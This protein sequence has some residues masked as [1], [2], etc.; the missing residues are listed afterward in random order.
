MDGSA[1]TSSRY[2]ELARSLAGQ[3]L[4]AAEDAPPHR[5]RGDRW[6]RS[7]TAAMPA[8][9]AL[10]GEAPAELTH[11]YR[12]G[13][14][15]LVEAAER[16]EAGESACFTDGFG[17][18]R[19]IYTLLNWHLHL[20]AAIDRPGLL[21]DETGDTRALLASTRSLGAFLT[22]AVG[23]SIDPRDAPTWLWLALCDGELAKALQQSRDTERFDP[24][25][26]A[27]LGEAPPAGSLQPRTDEPIEDWTYRE[28]IGLHAL[29]RL[30]DVTARAD[31]RERARQIATFH[32][33]HTQP[34]YITY[35]P[36]ALAA[37]ARQS[38]TAM[39]AEQQLH[40]VTLHLTTTGT[41][42]ALVPALLLADAAASL[43][44]TL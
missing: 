26:D 33:G 44:D 28:L 32:D 8:A 4:A 17:H 40:D 9:R 1:S 23:D 22:P 15:T 11:D 14:A 29:D 2:G 41:P 35:Q 5:P 39:F 19:A 7:L 30:A 37:F 36:W 43:R 3:A 31:W 21:D 25:I 10:V 38:A 13:L 12:A 27:M 24:R 6:Q 18:S 34:D 42:A 16:F 20:R